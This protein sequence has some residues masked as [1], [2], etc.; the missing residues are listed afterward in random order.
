MIPLYKKYSDA[1]P[2]GVYPLCNFGGLAILEVGDEEAVAAFNFGEGNKDIRKHKICYL[3]SG[4]AFIRKRRRR[5][6]ID[7]IERC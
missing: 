1:Q 4:R 7:E 3:P 6:Y 5:Y 2:V